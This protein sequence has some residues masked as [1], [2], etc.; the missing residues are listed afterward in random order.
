MRSL[1]QTDDSGWTTRGIRKS[2]RDYDEVECQMAIAGF[3]SE[4]QERD[5]IAD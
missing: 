1:P 3:L 5:D 4:H 2:G